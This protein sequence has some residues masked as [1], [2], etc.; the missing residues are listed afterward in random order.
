VREVTRTIAG[1][2]DFAMEQLG[3]D[4]EKILK[5]VNGCISAM[6]DLTIAESKIAR[7]HLDSVMKKMYMRSPD[8]LL[9][10]IQHDL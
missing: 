2:N 1:L 9:R 3:Y 7:R 4:K 8:T 10:T 5:A 6:S